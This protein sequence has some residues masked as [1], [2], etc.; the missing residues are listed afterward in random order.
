MEASIRQEEPHKVSFAA[1]HKPYI[2]SMA[3]NS[4]RIC[5]ARRPGGW[6]GEQQLCCV[7]NGGE[8]SGL[9]ASAAGAMLL[10]CML[11]NI[12]HDSRSPNAACAPKLPHS[13]SMQQCK[14]QCC[15]FIWYSAQQMQ[16]SAMLLHCSIHAVL[17][18][19]AAPDSR[20]SPHGP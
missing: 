17:T 3:H 2:T 5:K 15:L 6:Q 13:Y 12:A 7:H 19:Y 14:L 4:N 9:R 8:A 1:I 20:C 16:S 18:C 10:R 11:C